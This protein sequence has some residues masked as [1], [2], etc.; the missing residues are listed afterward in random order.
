MMVIDKKRTT[1]IIDVAVPLYW[2]FKD[3]EDIQMSGPLNIHAEVM[4]Y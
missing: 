2:K 4:E 3:K 1:T